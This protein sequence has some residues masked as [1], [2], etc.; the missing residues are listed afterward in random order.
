MPAGKFEQ[1]GLQKL[2][3]EQEVW[4]GTHSRGEMPSVDVPFHDITS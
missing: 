2:T 3:Q 4:V 1:L